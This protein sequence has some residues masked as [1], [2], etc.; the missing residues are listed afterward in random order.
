MKRIRT[1]AIACGALCAGGAIIFLLVAN[2]SND[3]KFIKVKT[4]YKAGST[5]YVGAQITARIESINVDLGTPVAAGQV[6]LTLNASDIARSIESMRDDLRTLQNNLK[7]KKVTYQELLTVLRFQESKNKYLTTIKESN[8]ATSESLRKSSEQALAKARTLFQEGAISKLELQKIE[9]EY[10][11]LKNKADVSTI[12]QKLFQ[13]VDVN[14]AAQGIIF[15][16]DKVLYSKREIENQIEVLTNQISIQEDKIAR[17]SKDLSKS[18][19]V[20]PA[21]GVVSDL[22]VNVGEVTQTGQKL[23]LITQPVK[24]WV[25]ALVS[26]NDIQD[27]RIGSKANIVFKSMPRKIFKGSVSF[28]SSSIQDAMQT[29]D[30]QMKVINSSPGSAS[31]IEKVIRVKLDFDD[32]GL[33][34]QNGI[35]ATVMIARN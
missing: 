1:I 13:D 11:D 19:I 30:Y 21:S 10:Q 26:E 35:S 25:D 7:E 27:I 18:V 29:S 8:Q 28:V 20:S 33:L 24:G 34:I 32:E 14:A 22:F 16:G 2:F 17:C 3:A 31:N 4:A 6:L 23:A 9:N 12:D 15:D 5:I